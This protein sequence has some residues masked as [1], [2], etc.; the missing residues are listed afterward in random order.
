MKRGSL[1]L[2]ICSL[3]FLFSSSFV[4]AEE[5]SPQEPSLCRVGDFNGDYELDI[6]D[7]IGL[8]NYLFNQGVPPSCDE[9]SVD[10]DGDGIVD[11]SDAIGLLSHLF[12]GGKG[13]KV[14]IV[15]NKKGLDVINEENV[16]TQIKDTDTIYQII[17]LR[18]DE[19]ESYFPIL[20]DQL[21][22]TVPILLWVF[23]QPDRKESKWHYIGCASDQK[24]DLI[25]FTRS[26][27]GGNVNNG[28]NVECSNAQDNM[29][30]F[31]NLPKDD[32][33]NFIDYLITGE[34]NDFIY[35][36]NR[37]IVNTV[38]VNG[39]NNLINFE[40][41]T[42]GLVKNS[43]FRP[44][45]NPYFESDKKTIRH[46]SLEFTKIS[47]QK[48]GDTIAMTGRNPLVLGGG[49]GV[50]IGSNGVDIVFGHPLEEY[51]FGSGG[52]DVLIGGGGEDRIY[53]DSFPENNVHSSFGIFDERI[54]F[55][56]DANSDLDDLVIGESDMDFI[57]TG[58]GDDDIYAGSNQDGI[59]T[60]DIIKGGDGDD[61]IFGD[62]K[63]PDTFDP[64][65]IVNEEIAKIKSS[66]DFNV[67]AIRQKIQEAQY[68]ELENLII[69]QLM[70]KGEIPN[71][72]G[73][74][75]VISGSCGNDMIFGEEGNDFIS[76][77]SAQK[78]IKTGEE[79]INVGNGETKTYN[80]YHSGDICEAENKEDKDIIFG[81]SG[82]DVL[83]GRL[84][85][86]LLYG[87]AGDDKIYG[88]YQDIGDNIEN[89]KKGRQNDDDILC[90]G[91]GLD[92][93]YGDTEVEELYKDPV[94]LKGKKDLMIAGP[95]IDKPELLKGGRRTIGDD[96]TFYHNGKCTEI[97]DDEIDRTE[98]EKVVCVKEWMPKAFPIGTLIGAF[99]G[100][101]DAEI[102]LPDCG[103][104]ELAQRADDD[105]PKR[106][107]PPRALPPDEPFPIEVGIDGPDSSSNIGCCS[108]V[109]EGP[110]APTYTQGTVV[111]CKQ[112]S[113]SECSCENLPTVCADG[114]AGMGD[115]GMCKSTEWD[116]GATCDEVNNKC[117]LNNEF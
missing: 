98:K 54:I 43:E 3:L 12:S 100:F 42:L 95:R 116:P 46:W 115:G 44:R 31:G 66:S 102:I 15:P 14:P 47:N 23:S 38:I 109:C 114:R 97:E 19:F 24:D 49:S 60:P 45:L 88:D 57:D 86:D 41:G 78:K 83:E 56:P 35:G 55:S 7:A 93:L 59:V 50:Y 64:E 52:N 103:E 21:S 67:K 8:L 2:G 9:E 63:G 94:Y 112:V 87:G 17:C 20:N 111:K 11:I 40:H 84:D 104:K 117:V 1:F 53:G 25:R 80:V 72:A 71:S 30:L 48:S 85:I 101:L 96:D 33:S 107:Y 29:I 4:L 58:P 36:F 92:K 68:K 22:C 34:G 39:G 27:K 26:T 51:I 75:D 16:Y 110:I 113:Q 13:P 74:S 108:M 89:W 91:E 79:T 70:T 77:T 69:Q 105:G 32:H 18:R 28:F 6:S 82:E 37:H 65:E 10:Y 5:T 106:P 99:R 62:K 73:G 90:G 81:G 61:L 76:G